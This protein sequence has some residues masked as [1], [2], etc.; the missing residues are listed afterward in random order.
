MFMS[1]RHQEGLAHLLYGINIGGG[2]VALTGEVGTGKTTLCH[3]LLQQLPPNIDIALILNPKQNALELLATI[4]DELGIRHDG[5]PQTS[6]NLI[7]AINRHL[8]AAY[9]NGRRTVLLIDE[10][11]NLSLDVLEQI[12]LLTNL[13]T[14]K[15][16]LLQI[17]LVGQPELQQLLKRQ[18]LRQLNQRITARYHLLPLSFEETR[19]YIQHRLTVCNGDPRLFKERA[20]RKIYRFSS[21]IPRVVNILCDR[22]LLGAYANNLHR[23]S[24]EVIDGAARETLGLGHTKRWLLTA[25]ATVLFGGLAAGAYFVS[26]N[27]SLIEQLGP[28]FSSPSRQPQAV[29]DIRQ[30][31][32]IA[33]PTPKAEPPKAEAK[34]FAAWLQDPA[35]SMDTALLAAL[36]VWQKPLPPAG[37]IDCEYVAST[38]LHCLSDNASWKDLLALNRP[39]ILQ[40]ALPP[41]QKR[42]ALLTGVDKGQAIFRSEEEFR[43]PIADVLKVWDGHFLLFWRS[44]QPDMTLITPQKISSNVIWLREQLNAG[45]GE[46][47]D[48]TRPSLFFDDALK[49]RV[50][51]FQ[52]RHHL[53]EDGIVGAQTLIHLDNQAGADTSPHLEI[54]E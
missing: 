33:E 34:S 3:C 50:I 20:I 39:A 29:A 14:S 9:A 45:L 47:E 11:Q 23:I 21:G 38:G 41:E 49:A 28:S 54:T 7:D 32:S 44:P 18:D 48:G 8:L 6:K 2:F 16:K 12:R 30:T 43:F 22:A 27:P 25:A 40:F 17:I 15:A 37:G 1:E 53:L 19:A 51:E 10:A 52:H 24:A 26:R 35:L 46:T 4:R 42:H 5:I 31:P 13:E 36:K